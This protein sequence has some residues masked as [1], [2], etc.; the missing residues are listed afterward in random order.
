M[1]LA[2]NSALYQYLEH[3]AAECHLVGLETLADRLRLANRFSI[4][5]STEFLDE[6]Q[7]ALELVLREAP[8]HL[9]SLKLADVRSAINQIKQAFDQVGGGVAYPLLARACCT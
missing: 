5:S 8:N 3:L 7:K 1:K 2:S 4:G 9:S 6:A